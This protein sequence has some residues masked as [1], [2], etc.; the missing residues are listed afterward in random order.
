MQA[1]ERDDS[2]PWARY[3]PTARKLSVTLPLSGPPRTQAERMVSGLPYSPIDPELL[4]ARLYIRIQQRLHAA[5]DPSDPLATAALLHAMVGSHGGNCW[6][7]PPCYF[8][9]GGN[10]H[11]GDAVYANY[12]CTFLDVAPIRI[13]DRTMLA[14]GCQLLTAT[15]PVNTEERKTGIEYGKAITIGSDCWL[16]GGVIVC[17]GVTIGDGAVVG[18]G[19]VVVRDVAPYTVV[20]GNPARL[21]RHIP[22]TLPGG[23]VADHTTVGGPAAHG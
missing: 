7:E 13:G 10:T 1:S 9:Y 22:R 15:H 21:I 14:S 11:L 6:F 18:A 23:G 3:K 12:N 17:P 4:D 8:D 2:P 19:A 5:S 20:A 16:G